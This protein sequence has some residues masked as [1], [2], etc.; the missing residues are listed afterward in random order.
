MIGAELLSTASLT[1]GWLIYL[2]VLLSV[3]MRSPSVR[4]VQ[5]Q[6]P[7][8]LAV[9]H[10]VRAISAVAGARDLDTG[11]S[12]HFIGMTAVTLLL[13]LLLA[14]VGGLVA[15]MGAG[16]AGASGPGCGG[17]QWRAA[18]SA[19][20]AHHRMRGSRG[21]CERTKSVVYIFCSGFFAA[22]LW[23]VVPDSESDVAAGTTASSPCR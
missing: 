18:D 3:I 8:A 14:I 1:L 17:R 19:A 6:S 12:Y 5:R 21:A 22:A 13:D 16:A 20:S 4:A 11:V 23:P 15:Q 2:S 10:G 7:A 9:R